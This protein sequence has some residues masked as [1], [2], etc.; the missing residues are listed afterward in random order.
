[1]SLVQSL[2]S[3]AKTSSILKRMQI[4]ALM[5]AKKFDAALTLCNSMFSGESK[6]QEMVRL[7]G[8]CLYQTGE[9]QKAQMHFRQLLQNDP[10][11]S[12]I[13][14]IFKQVKK[15]ESAK[16][17]ANDAFKEGKTQQAF[18]MYT[19]ALTLDP[20]HGPYNSVMR[21]N[22]AAAA[23]KQGRYDV[24]ADDC[25]K[26]IEVNSEYTKAYL[27]RADC[28]MQLNKFDDALRDFEVVQKMQDTRDPELARKIRQCKLEQ[29][30]AKRKDYYKILE[31]SKDATLQDVKKSYRKL[32]LIWHPDR[33]GETPEKAKAA[34]VKFKGIGEAYEILSDEKKRQRYDSGADLEE[35]ADFGP[36]MDVNEIFRAMF[37]GGGF[38]FGGG[39]GGQR[40]SHGGFPGG[41]FGFE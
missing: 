22:R 34:E 10:D 27:R 14:S 32:A 25:T 5:G 9:Y 35:G 4:E 3:V 23:M 24:A 37:G 41:H 33:N 1:L 15:M 17:A 21:C 31:V 2:L 20:N 19:Q 16:D 30:K 12:K 40:H 26:A 38:S 36:S 6:D 7:R 18:E 8:M 39:H 29:K 11:N 13:Q 28:Y